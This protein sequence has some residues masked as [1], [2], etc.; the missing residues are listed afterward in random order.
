M[1]NPIKST[2]IGSYPKPEYIVGDITGHKTVLIGKILSDLEKKVG[3]E[4]Y[5]TLINCAVN[6]AIDD[7]NDSGINIVTDGEQRREHYVTYVLRKLK[8]FDFEDMCKKEVKKFISGKFQTAYTVLAPIVVSRVEHNGPFLVSDF[9]YASKRTNREVKVTIPG[10]STVVD[11][12]KNMFY[13]SD[14]ELAFGYSKAIRKEVSALKRAGCKIIQF[15]DPG[16]LR[17]LTRSEEWGISA[18]DTCFA[19]IDVTIVVHVCRSYPNK[20]YEK[21]NVAY[22][23]DL[24]YYPHLLNL[25]QK[26]SIDQIS[27]EAKQGNLDPSI[28]KN[29]GSKTVILGCIDVG[30]E[31]VETV[32]EIIDQAKAALRYI[33]PE[34]LVLGPDCG[35]LELSRESSKT[36]LTNLARASEILNSQ[37]S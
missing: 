37:I 30:N 27:I 28:L 21:K 12:V 32:N 33:K 9:E 2:I 15:D 31:R 4:K 35:L 7:Q 29:L 20:K 19:G 24:G 11:H 26:S 34:Q 6:Q 14:K 36:K 22:K 8:G 1:A 18:L 5:Q 25:L 17:N 23:S 3:P 13:K 16:L 10:P